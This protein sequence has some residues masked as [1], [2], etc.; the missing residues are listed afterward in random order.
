MDE[1]TAIRLEAVTVDPD[2][3]STTKRIKFLILSVTVA[4]LTIICLT[5]FH[6]DQ[7]PWLESFPSS[8]WHSETQPNIRAV[9]AL[10]GKLKVVKTYHDR[11]VY[12]VD[13]NNVRHIIPDWS[14]FLTLGYDVGDIITLNEESMAE[15]KLG[16]PLDP[17]HE[18]PTPP[19]PYAGCPCISQNQ[20]LVS[21]KKKESETTAAAADT[22]VKTDTHSQP[23]HGSGTEH[24]HICLV[25][26]ANTE[27]FLTL[28][29][30]L[31]LHKVSANALTFSK[32]PSNYTQLSYHNL[33]DKSPDLQRCDVVMEFTKKADLY[34]YTCPEQCSPIPYTL[35]SLAWLEQD[36][37]IHDSK[38]TEGSKKLSIDI[39]L[40]CSMTW[41]QLFAEGTSLHHH[42]NRGNDHTNTVEETNGLSHHHL[43]I[44]MMIKAIVRRRIE[45]CNERE[46]W[47]TVTTSSS[48]DGGSIDTSNRKYTGM[49]KRQVH[50][51][52]AWVGS[53]TRY[54]L[55]EDQIQILTHT[56]KFSTKPSFHKDNDGKEQ[57]D[58]DLIVGWLASEDQY[59]CRVGSTVCESV[60][61][62]SAYYHYMPTTRMNVAS[63]GWSCAQ[64]RPLRT[65]SHI[66]LLYDM[67]YLMIVDDDTYVSI[68]ILLSNPFKAYTRDYLMKQSLVIGQLTHGKKITR[69]GFYWGGSGYLLSKIVIDRLNGYEIDGPMETMNVMIDPTMMR[70]LSVFNQVYPMSQQYCAGCLNIVPSNTSKRILN[71]I[72]VLNKDPNTVTSYIGLKATSNV[73]LIELCVNLMAQEH[74]CY[75]SDHSLS[76]CFIHGAYA[77]PN[78]AE[79]G[80]SNFPNNLRMG[81]CMGVGEC[82]TST[83]LTCHRWRPYHADYTRAYGYYNINNDT[84][85]DRAIPHTYN[86][87]SDEDFYARMRERRSLRSQE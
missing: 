23:E 82:E 48:S 73:R 59:P 11:S 32:I 12:V 85:A 22:S 45:E 20:F 41:R 77:Y 7:F 64:R 33:T 35:I 69:R 34:K 15:L 16:D 51:M 78:D 40:T 67:N 1:V 28:Y 56:T 70:D 18:E 17:I 29:S 14:T 68:N 66:L 76:R 25:E 79:C 83:L 21:L 81:M 10:G 61:S 50:G 44:S 37:F 74:T 27:K 65:L 26:G 42:H 43:S 46:Y 30:S 38:T 72:T 87:P 24:H 36:A 62:S 57:I 80:V 86:F 84:I 31:T 53:R 49:S 52:I 3:K 71:D 60:T 47:R 8:W 39:P 6:H 5:S 58:E 13:G 63:A 75:H 54:E 4:L 2:Q 55:M 9:R 19:N